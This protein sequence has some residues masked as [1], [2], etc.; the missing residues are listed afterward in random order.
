MRSLLILIASILVAPALFAT[1]DC[2]KRDISGATTEE[3]L[4]ALDL[5]KNEW[6]RNAT[7]CKMGDFEVATPTYNSDTNQNT[8]FI[9]KQGKPVFYRQNTT[10][11]IYSTKLKDA[12]FAYPIV[13]MW[14][15]TD[16]EDVKRIWYQTVGKTPQ[17]MVYDTNFDGQPDLKTIWENNEIIEAYKWKDNH[18]I[19]IESDNKSSNKP[20]KPMR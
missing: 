7:I 16:E 19:I 3:E 11:Y 1:P 10:S 8:I 12:S 9:F 18:W 17:V 20:I 5:T 14:H 6:M 13:N 4:F 15:G 2:V